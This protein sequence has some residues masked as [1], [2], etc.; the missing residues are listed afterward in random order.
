MSVQ[1]L[2][3]GNNIV[4]EIQKKQLSKETQK[5]FKNAN[6]GERINFE[7]EKEIQN[8]IRVKI[9]GME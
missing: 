1:D 6:V 3:K 8:K 2:I 9:M 4:I 7:I 5:A